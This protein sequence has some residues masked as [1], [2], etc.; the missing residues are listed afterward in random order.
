MLNASLLNASMINANM[1]DA[2][3]LNAM[4]NIILAT[5]TQVVKLVWERSVKNSS[6]KKIQRGLTLV[7][8]VRTKP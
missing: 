1:L 5:G 2:S 8:Y 4:Q 3:M 7:R 6:E